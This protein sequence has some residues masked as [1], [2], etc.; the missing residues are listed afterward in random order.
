MKIIQ[1]NTVYKV[2]STGKIVDKLYNL[3]KEKGF[4]CKVVY[5][6]PEKN[7]FVD[8]IYASS[9][10]D[11]HIHNR[12][13]R[14][15]GLQGWFS[16]LRTS[17]LV[18]YFKKYKPDLIHLHNLHG[19]YVNLKVLFR[20]IKK[21]NI[22]VIWTLHDCWAFTGGCPHFLS[23]NCYK[24]KKQCG[25]CPLKFKLSKFGLD[26]TSINYN[27]KKNLFTN[28]NDL[29]IVTPSKW[30][31]CNIR[32]SFLSNYRNIVIS[33]GINLEIFK[34]TPSDFRQKYN[35][36]NEKKIVLGVAFDWGIAKGIDVFVYLSKKLDSSKYQ[37]IL[38]GTTESIVKQL[39]KNII[40]INKTN[41]QIELA[42]IYS[43]ASVFVNPTREEMFGLVN[44]EA[45][46]CGIPVITFNTGGCPECISEN[47]GIL[48]D[49]DDFDSLEKNI[50]FVC[51]QSPFSIDSCVENAKRFDENKIY[52]E[53]LK[54]YE[55]EG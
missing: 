40:A 39:P 51:E 17:K 54:L 33:N 22:R 53:Y 18:K 27:N 21:N 7:T 47:S 55:Q 42:K 5:R 41:D 12:L 31:Q 3:S 50:I 28:I 23:A 1:I 46:A 52:E 6:Y 38:V 16:F 19:S 49:V 13:N 11:C 2:G 48:V 32:E 36:L 15:T 10:L 45:N 30:L 25:N 24:W 8:T 34:P 43:A 44:V 14:Y 4:E 9:W 35:I 20:Y 37:I 26:F 29:T